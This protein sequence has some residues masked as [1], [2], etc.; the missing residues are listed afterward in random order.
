MS[1]LT[2]KAVASH[3]NGLD[4]SPQCK[5]Q[6]DHHSVAGSE[7]KQRAYVLQLSCRSTRGPPESSDCS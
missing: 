1:T 3:L 2:K 6:G 5:E 4:G 7:G